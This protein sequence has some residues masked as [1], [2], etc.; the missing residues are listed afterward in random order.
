MIKS[1]LIANRGEIACR[2]IRT[3]KKLNIRTIVIYSEAD[4]HSLS[5][6]MSDESYCIGPAPLDESY[7]NI[8]KIIE[9][10]QKA[11][12][13]AIHPGYGFLS[14]SEEFSR[15]CL[16]AGFIFIGP[17]LEAL[18]KM[19]SKSEA[20]KIAIQ[21]D[22][23]VILGI[24][25]DQ[26]Y[27]L[28]TAERIG[29]P[30][31]IKAVMGGGGKG[32]RRV[33]KKEELRESLN[34]CK[35]EAL[36]YFGNDSLIIEKYISKPRHIEVQI[37][38]DTH[39]NLIHLFERDCSLQRRHQKVIEETPSNI[40][41]S[42][43]EKL[44]DASLKIGKAIKY[45]GAGTVEFLVDHAGHFYF[46]EMNTRL[47]VEHP[48][49]ELRTGLDLVEWQFRIAS[50]EELPL[51]QNQVNTQGHVIELRL[52]AE[53]PYHEFKPSPGPIWMKDDLPHLRL[54]TG[55]KPKDVV[56]PYYD[57]LIAKLI[58]KG[59][60][61]SDAFEAAKSGLAKLTILG[62]KTNASFLR[63][64]LSNHDIIEDN[65]DSGYIDHHIKSLAQS[66]N[67]PDEVFL[68]ASLIKVL[69]PNQH[70]H[71]PWEDHK[72]WRLKGYAPISFE[73]ASG[74]C[75]K[76]VSLTYS[77]EGWTLSDGQKI[78]GEIKDSTLFYFGKEIPYWDYMGK[79]SLF[80]EGETFM[81][82]LIAFVPKG[83]KHSEDHLRAPMTGKVIV[84]HVKEGD[85]VKEGQPLL[86]LEAMKME[87]MIKAPKKGKVKHIFHRVGD[88]VN[89]GI[90]L[91]DL[92]DIHDP[93]SSR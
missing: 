43:K 40:P 37:F 78:Q 73:W 14:E 2:I 76:T 88:V 70:P 42:L 51:T 41:D 30:L 58:V 86:I 80:Y 35:R 52:Y 65:F 6:Q 3:A 66:Q 82:D 55:L 47:Q 32:M 33:E 1:V 46:M 71:S 60:T 64:L 84:I 26:N 27:L 48:I 45:V 8:P 50:G 57:P 89:E 93:S 10:A 13:E 75:F 77:S 85:T 12:V 19:G 92:G 29:Y 20:K 34:A 18:K 17:S 90:E 44:F 83:H 79:L 49:T 23:P 24:E 56:S 9:V 68:A 5:V 36:A 81:L 72:N 54:D 59:E 31:M 87:H 22:I 74:D 25:G 91:F 63:N 38:G 16:D 7:L 53:D 61:R 62:L 21:S 11:N 15:A 67:T 39:G 28:Q 4:A 69:M